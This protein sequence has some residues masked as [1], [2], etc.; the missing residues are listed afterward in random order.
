MS[1]TNVTGLYSLTFINISLG[2][3]SMIRK[4]HQ[5]RATTEQLNGQQQSQQ[6]FKYSRLKPFGANV[7][8]IKR[9]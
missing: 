4:C 8:F 7:R 6:N 2:G 5:Y 9:H 3:G 1:E